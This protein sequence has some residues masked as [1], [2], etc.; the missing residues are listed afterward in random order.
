MGAGQIRRP[1]V[2]L[3][4]PLL[5][6][7][8]SACGIDRFQFRNDHRLTFEQPEERSLVELPLTITWQM[9]GFDAVGL[10][11]SAETGRGAYA[12]FVDR[13]PMPVG[14]DL[15][16]VMRNFPGCDVDAQCPTVDQLAE[17]D[18][19][20]TTDTTV[21][22]EELGASSTASGDE[23]HYV[24]VVLVNGEG[25]RMLESAWYLPFKTE[26]DER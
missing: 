15:R 11:G 18:I 6:L 20:L 3:A 19:H 22:L 23:E 14:R 7:S 16:W 24:N 9:E 5:V 1:L 25:E 4:V 12:V 21:T 26:R 17:R 10:D 8:L 13:A 2:T